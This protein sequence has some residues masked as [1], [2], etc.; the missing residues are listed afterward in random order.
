MIRLASPTAMGAQASSSLPRASVAASSSA[1]D[2]TRLAN[3]MRCASRPSITFP[4]MIS[5]LALPRPT[6]AGSREHPPTSGSS[7]TRTS[8]IPATASSAITRKSHASASSNAPPRQPPWIWQMVGFVISSSRF[9]QARMGWRNAR[10]F[11]ESS[12]RSRRSER[13]IPDENIA[14]SPRTTTTR[15]LSSVAAAST[16]APSARIRSP[17]SALRFSGR[18]STRWRTAPRSSI[19]I[20]DIR[21]PYPPQRRADV[22]V[23]GLLAVRVGQGLVAVGLERQVVH[24][25]PSEQLPGRDP[26]EGVLEVGLVV[27]LVVARAVV[28]PAAAHAVCHSAERELAAP[29]AQVDLHRH[30]ALD[31][32]V[33]RGRRARAGE[34]AIE[35]PV[36]LDVAVAVKGPDPP[37]P[38]ANELDLAGPRA[39]D[40]DRLLAALGPRAASLD[41]LAV[42][43]DLLSLEGDLETR[44]VGGRGQCERRGRRDQEAADGHVSIVRR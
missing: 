2:A 43:R 42:A 13:S 22:H 25:P 31:A 27:A 33:V 32:A 12:E 41:R 35:A 9:H 6:T 14:P 20:S 23:G 17:L 37:V 16:A 19:S 3:P 24:L 18:F 34:G 38:Q 5:S 7:P 8:M 1:A 29:V 40:G 36:G 44:G 15:T 11:D 26:P 10:R 28:R 30:R 21:L 39:R 4:V